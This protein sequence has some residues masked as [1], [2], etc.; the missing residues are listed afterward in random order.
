MAKSVNMTISVP[1]DIIKMIEKY[2]IRNIDINAFK[3]DFD[4]EYLRI[5]NSMSEEQIKQ[6][7]AYVFGKN[8]ESFFED[9][10]EDI[11]TIE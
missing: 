3:H 5:K 8:D 10:P 7:E 1:S 4:I 2:N 11:P 6:L 9:M